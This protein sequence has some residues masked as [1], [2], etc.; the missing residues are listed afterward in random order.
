MTDNLHFHQPWQ[1]N[2]NVVVVLWRPA[3]EH[4]VLESDVPGGSGG[5]ESRTWAGLPL[6]GSICSSAV[7]CRASDG[8][9]WPAKNCRTNQQGA[10]ILLE[11]FASNQPK[12]NAFVSF[13]RSTWEAQLFHSL[14]FLHNSTALKTKTHQRLIQKACVRNNIL[15]HYSYY[16]C[17][18]QYIYCAQCVYCLFVQEPRWQWSTT[19]GYP[20]MQCTWLDFFTPHLFGLPKKLKRFPQKL[21]SK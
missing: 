14:A 2:V 21:D 20:R 3:E 11:T 19:H 1:I 17:S 6:E 10:A 12:K 8:I 18:M 9:T 4:A 13:S 15:S 16:F 7:S 5:V